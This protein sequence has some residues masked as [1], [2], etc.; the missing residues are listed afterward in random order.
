MDVS[1]LILEPS[2][3]QFGPLRRDFRAEADSEWGVRLVSSTDELLQRLA[4]RGQHHLVSVPEDPGLSL[5]P[6]IREAADE[7]LA[8]LYDRLT[9][10]TIEVPPLRDRNGDVEVLAEYFLNQ[11]AREI[12]AFRGKTLSKA[13]VA[14][15]RSHRFPGNV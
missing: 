1:L 5:I 15:L 7:F 14:V 3:S 4:D 8:D 10:E 12:P 6:T 2:G 13:A 11:F 9:F